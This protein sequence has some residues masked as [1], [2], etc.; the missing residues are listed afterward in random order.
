MRTRFPIRMAGLALALAGPALAQPQP[1]K[2]QAQAGGVAVFAAR[3]ARPTAESTTH[4]VTREGLRL[5]MAVEIGTIRVRTVPGAQVVTVQMHVET[6]PRQPDAEKLI[7]Q[8]TL[9]GGSSAEGVHVTSTVPWSDFRGRLWVRFEVTTPRN[10]SLELTTHAGNIF[11]DDV[12]GRVVL[13]SRGGNIDTG[14]VGG[15]ARLESD[16]GHLSMGNVGGDVIALTAGGH[17]SAGQI[18]GSATLHTG[19]GH[20]RVASIQGAGNAETGGGDISVARAGGK[21]SAVSEAGGQ[22]TFAEASGA[23]EA[24]TAGG[25]VRVLKMTGPMQL[26]TAGSIYLTQVSEPVRA[27]TASG[28]ITAWFATAGAKKAPSQLQSSEGD[29]LVYLPRQLALNIDATIE[30]AAGHQ[31]TWDPAIPI[32]LVSAPQPG[33]AGG[34]VIRATGTMNGGG[35]TLKLHA[36]GGNIRLMRVEQWSPE[37]YRTQL[38]QIE[39]EIQ[40]QRA[41]LR[42]QQGETFHVIL[43]KEAVEQQQQAVAVEEKTRVAYLRAMLEDLFTRTVRVDP[44]EQASRLKVSVMPA[45]PEV[46]RR[47]RVEGTVQLEVVLSE[48]GNV[49]AVRPVSGH[50]LLVGAARD[51]VLQWQYQPTLVGNRPVRVVTRIDVQ[52]KLNSN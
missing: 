47:V 14:N 34:Q 3:T 25:G 20:I 7:K 32:K 9:G 1:A 43:R 24:R 23:I 28:N 19:G 17:V 5:R 27:S 13:M 16:G 31:V 10:Y 35:E 21:F 4:Y 45:Y 48:D 39:R 2:P 46:A 11:T 22:I 12:D 29:I 49:V 36:V 33:K 6:D 44:L 15:S 42:G 18:A 37:A 41:Y 30:S 40:T 51:A 52:F 50:P 8:V 38:E 26:N